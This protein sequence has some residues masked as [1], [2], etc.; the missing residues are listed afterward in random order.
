[1]AIQRVQCPKCQ[2]AMNVAA[3]MATVQ[4]SGCNNVFPTSPTE[5]AQT[6]PDPKESAV[7]AMASRADDDGDTFTTTKTQ[8][9][10]VASGLAGFLVL[11]LVFFIFL[12]STHTETDRTTQP[13]SAPPSG[14]TNSV[15]S[16]KDD[17]KP[18]YRVVAISEAERRR[19]YR[20]YH[21]MEKSGFGKA[22]RIPQGGKAGQALNNMLGEIAD[23]E[24]DLMALNNRL[25]DDDIRQIVAEGKAKGWD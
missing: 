1:M 24:V 8:K 17:A 5:A 2:T 16:E 19:L 6:G 22:K 15:E 21:T 9:I 23:R 13:A 20:E 4:C 14:S 12:R 18:T 25:S 11:L 7:R 3:T 10:A